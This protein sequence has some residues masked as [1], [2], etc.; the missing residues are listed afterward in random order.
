MCLITHLALPICHL[1]VPQPEL[2]VWEP[3]GAYP[4]GPPEAWVPRF[5]QE[6]AA[7]ER[8]DVK[9]FHGCNAG[10]GIFFLAVVPWGVPACPEPPLQSRGTSS[11]ILRA[12]SLSSTRLISKP[13]EE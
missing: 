3:P 2:Q 13:N 4:H 5:W 1:R 9:S 11:T 6:K 7:G 10:T 8:G 12:P